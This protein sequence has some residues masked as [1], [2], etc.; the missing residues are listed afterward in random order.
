MNTSIGG[1]E[2]IFND[3]NHTGKN[4]EAV[5]VKAVVVINQLYSI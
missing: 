4:Q 2:K 3:R 5:A 1:R